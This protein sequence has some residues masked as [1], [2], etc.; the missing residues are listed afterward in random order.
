MGKVPDVT[1][2]FNPNMIKLTSPWAAGSDSIKSIRW[3]YNT[4]GYINR[5]LFLL[6]LAHQLEGKVLYL[7]SVELE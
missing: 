1:V 3:V 5:A 7:V 2:Q 6:P 4:Q